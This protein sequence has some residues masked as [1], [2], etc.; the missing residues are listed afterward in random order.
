MADIFIMNKDQKDH[1]TLPILELFEVNEM[2]KLA[3]GFRKVDG[4]IEITLASQG[5]DD[6]IN[7]M[8]TL[9][10]FALDNILE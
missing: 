7:E 8:A 6:D 2:K 4:K 1:T 5:M 9:L 10:A 3:L